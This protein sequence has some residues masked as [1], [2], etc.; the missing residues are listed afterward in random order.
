MKSYEQ[1]LRRAIEL[2]IQEEKDSMRER[3]PIASTGGGQS[4]LSTS[5]CR[6]SVATLTDPKE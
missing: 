2:G 4:S 1:R 6:A 5:R 3:N